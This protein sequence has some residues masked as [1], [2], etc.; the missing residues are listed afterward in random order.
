MKYKMIA[1]DM[2]GTLLNNSKEVSEFSRKILKR[3]AE[4]GVKLVVCTGRIFTSARVYARLIGTE[5]PIIASNGA[6]IREKDRNEIIF[7]R[8]LSEDHIKK[9]VETG[10]RYGLYPHVFTADTIYTKKLVFFSANYNRW[11]QTLP[12]DERV[13]IEIVDNFDS[14]IRENKGRILK[15]VVADDDIERVMSAKEEIKN[16]MDVSIFSSSSNNFEVMAP[17]I[18][19][20]YAVKILSKY[21]GISRE[22][23]ICIGDNENDT[24]MIEYAG[25]GIAMGNATEELKQIASYITDTNENDG[26]A[27]A[28]EKFVL[29]C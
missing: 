11:N 6:Y 24:S 25:L 22:E 3:A 9:V 8:Y 15:V 4:K 12:E 13:K 2:D 28:V 1:M 7:Q 20:G 23:I 10:I 19:K 14:A 18:S 17:E 29:N 26:V 5:A 16:T 21:Y 27:K